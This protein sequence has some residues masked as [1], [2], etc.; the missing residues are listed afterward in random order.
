M[1]LYINE[2]WDL[3]YIWDLNFCRLSALLSTVAEHSHLHVIG[4]DAIR[5]GSN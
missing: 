1:V 5:H 3:I 4:L 2:I